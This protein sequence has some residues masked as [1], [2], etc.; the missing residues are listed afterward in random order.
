[1][2]NQEDST[3]TPLG[4]VV[5]PIQVLHCTMHGTV[6]QCP[7]V[8]MDCTDAGDCSDIR[9]PRGSG[10]TTAAA[11]MPEESWSASYSEIP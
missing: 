8:W 4:I 10:W 7:W 11:T 6:T 9:L 2:I 1:M 3:K 5:D